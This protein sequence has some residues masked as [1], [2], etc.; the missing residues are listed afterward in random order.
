MW[1][2]ARGQM[3]VAML[4]SLPVQIWWSLEHPFWQRWHRQGWASLTEQE[5][6]PPHEQ[7]LLQCKPAN[8]SRSGKLHPVTT[9]SIDNCSVWSTP[10]SVQPYRRSTIPLPSEYELQMLAWRIKVDLPPML[11]PVMTAKFGE[12]RLMSLG[13]KSPWDIA[14]C[15]SCLT[16]N[17]WERFSQIQTHT[18][19]V[20]AIRCQIQTLRQSEIWSLRPS[21]QSFSVHCYHLVWRFSGLN[22]KGDCRIGNFASAALRDFRERI[23]SRLAAIEQLRYL[24]IPS[25][26]LTKPESLIK[27]VLKSLWL[28]LLAYG[29]S[30]ALD[31]R[32]PVAFS[33]IRTNWYSFSGRM[34]WTS[35]NEYLA[36]QLSPLNLLILHPASGTN[37][38]GS[39]H[40]KRRKALEEY[41]N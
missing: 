29:I 4:G 35:P 27:S 16:A 37:A 30:A 38:P 34:H 11:G 24:I 19:L 22:W 1:C 32:L 36:R 18:H 7:V 10:L 8:Y 26:S 9:K 28:D 5:H 39:W 17:T 3:I 13:T 14:G 33:E 6:R 41:K 21:L 2:A 25:E 31:W 15:L 40:Y 12:P 20:E 23:C